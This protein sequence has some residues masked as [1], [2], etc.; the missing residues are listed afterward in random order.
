MWQQ[1]EANIT[2]AKNSEGITEC[3]LVS[4][5]TNWQVTRV[6]IVARPE[7]TKQ[8]NGQMKQIKNISCINIMYLNTTFK[9]NYYFLW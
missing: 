1:L 5:S 8:P 3:M 9:Q 2:S 7:G 6:K 4:V